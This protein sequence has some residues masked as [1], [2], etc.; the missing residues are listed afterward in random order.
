MLGK[1]FHEIVDVW[2]PGLHLQFKGTKKGIPYMDCPDRKTNGKKVGKRTP[3]SF[4]TS[5]KFLNW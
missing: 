4:L 3:G 2:S 1:N 5:M